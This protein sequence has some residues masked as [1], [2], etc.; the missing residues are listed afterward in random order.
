M[1]S[2]KF[3]LQF[4]VHSDGLEAPPSSTQIYHTSFPHFPLLPAELR[5]QIWSCLLLP[6]IIMVSCQD[7]NSAAEQD[8]ELSARPSRPLVPVL[9]HVN[10][11]ARALALAHYELAFSWKVPAV[12]ADMDLLASSWDADHYHHFNHHGNG[13]AGAGGADNDGD[14]A[15]AAAAAATTAEPP[16]WS[17]PRVYFNFEHDAL[18]LLGELELYTSAGFN[19]PM[20]YFLRRE[21]T[22]RVRRVAVS[23]RALR[24]GESGSQQIFGTLFHVVDR[25]S[26]PRG[27]RVLVCV[28]EADELTHA[29]MGGAGPLVAASLSSYCSSGDGAES[30]EVPDYAAMRRRQRDL[31]LAAQRQRQQDAAAATAE[32]G[33]GGLV[34][35]NTAVVAEPGQ[36]DEVD[37]R[38][39][40]EG[41]E[42]HARGSGRLED[43]VMQKIWRDWYRGSIVR[44]SLASME[45]KLIREV[46]VRR[47]IQQDT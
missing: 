2:P 24:Y 14:A 28:T 22:A 40:W 4:Q 9:L 33:G 8:L 42:R 13:G 41:Y 36:H 27:G 44:S 10:H 1:A 18:F 3:W 17:E 5:L 21:E 37:H 16:R 23:F 12:L 11:E 47:H 32:G 46:D 15:A 7:A 43:N 29:L 26:Q 25:L 39:L 20:T 38:D 19:S 45:F 34:G 6:R 35:S 30:R 31:L